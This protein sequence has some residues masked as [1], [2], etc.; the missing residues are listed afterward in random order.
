MVKRTREE[1]EELE[2]NIEEGKKV[3]KGLCEKL[4]N[5]KLGEQLELHEYMLKAKEQEKMT[6]AFSKDAL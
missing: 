1:K 3:V 2:R 6:L 4:M 5:E